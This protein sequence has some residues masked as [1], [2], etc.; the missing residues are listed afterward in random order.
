METLIG[1]CKN[2]IL[3]VFTPRVVP[4]RSLQKRKSVRY[5]LG[6][7]PYKGKSLEKKLEEANYQD[8]KIYYKV[9]IGFP[10]TIQN[11]TEG[12]QQRIAHSKKLKGNLELEKKARE[13][14]LLVCLD[15]VS[16][17]WSKENAPEHIKSAAEYYGVF[18]DLFGDA[19]FYPQVGLHVA[20]KF[21]QSFVPVY[22]GNLIKPNQALTAPD[23]NYNSDPDSLWTLVA[24]NPDGHLEKN[25]VEFLHW[26]LGNIPGRDISKGEVIANYIQPFPARGT[27]FQRLIFIL[28]KQ[29]EK[30]NYSSLTLPSNKVDMKNRTFKT[31]DFYRNHQDQLTPTGLAFCQVDW[32]LSVSHFFHTVMDMDEPVY[33]YD[34]NP[35]YHPKQKMFPI[36]QPFNLYMDRYRDAKQIAKEY[37]L[38]KLK[39]SHPFK[40]PKPSLK[41][42][43]AVPVYH[44]LNERLH[45]G[46]PSWLKREKIKERLGHGRINDY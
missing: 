4:I 10:Q 21:E 46:I 3:K 41:Y 15:D 12:L 5:M 39:N 16:R 9:D 32:D 1:L 13:N 29:T 44:D 25:N 22:R 40:D 18:Q 27:G 24:T 17:E 26:F 19:F 11:R 7:P 30:I 35:P 31:Y 23:I 38:K 42:P 20:F 45:G 36:R 14:K 33:E 43:N 8:P 34:F 2:G 28:Y 37:L 6:V